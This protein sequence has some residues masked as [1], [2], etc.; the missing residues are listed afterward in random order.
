MDIVEVLGLDSLLA[1]LVLAI[2]G[3]MILGNGFAIYQHRQGNV[4]KGA[5]GV[6]R[7]SRAWWLLGVGVVIAL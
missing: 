5:Q 1:Q 6:F 3:A 7:A 2:G 4:P